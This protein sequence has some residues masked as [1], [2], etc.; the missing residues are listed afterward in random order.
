[1]ITT[2]DHMLTQNDPA[3]YPPAVKA[4]R[5]IISFLKW[6][7]SLL[8][9]NSYRWDPATDITP[10]QKGSEIFIGADTPLQ[11][12]QVGK[13]P[14]ITVLRSQMAYQGVGIGDKSYVDLRTGA[15]SY[16]DL[17]PTTIGINVLSRVDVV[18]ERLAG[19]VQSQIFALRE[20]IVKTEPCI[21]NIGARAGISPPTPAGTLV[22]TPNSDW[23][24]VAMAY[25][26]F[27]Q[28]SITKT[29]L[30]KTI[31]GEVNPIIRPR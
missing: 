30:N 5:H 3:F 25:P 22:D 9:L 27:L 10:D 20:E 11:T 17:V 8:P 6:R 14:A 2:P 4:V 21:L 16:L 19:F 28:D 7:F 18:A 29:P 24:C 12:A 31:V 13:R 23:R 26:T 15:R 1:M